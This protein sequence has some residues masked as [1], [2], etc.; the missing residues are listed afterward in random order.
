QDRS[1]GGVKVDVAVAV[2]I[3]DIRALAAADAERRV[4]LAS[5]RV[6]APGCDDAGAAEEFGRSLVA[7]HEPD[8]RPELSG[9]CHCS[10]APLESVGLPVVPAANRSRSSSMSQAACSGGQRQMAPGP[11]QSGK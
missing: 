10:G 5:R 9:T 4:D 6:D 7:R 11:T 8:G 3:L 2:E 1:V